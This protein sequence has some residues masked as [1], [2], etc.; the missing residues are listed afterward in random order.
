MPAAIGFDVYGTLVD[1][2]A[3]AEP[4]RPIVGD[5]ADDFARSWRRTQLEYAFRRALMRQYVPFDVC[6]RQALEHAAREFGVELSEADR[7][8]LIVKTRELPPFPDAAPALAKLRDDGHELMAFS[9]GLEANVRAVLG[10][11]GILD[12]LE[13]VVSADDI[14]TFKPDP[15]A[16][17]HLLGRLSRPSGETWVVSA[18]PWDVLGAKAAGL[19]AVWVQRHPQVFDTWDVEP[20]LIVTSLEELPARLA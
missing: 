16:Y 20:D 11:A 19:Q 2:L 10:H 8:S 9:N 6:I 13:G 14:E 4:L 1:P 15:R 5:R 18:N 7:Q 17:H 12:Y 3:I